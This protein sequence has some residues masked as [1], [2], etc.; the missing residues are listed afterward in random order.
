MNQSPAVAN[1]LCHAVLPDILGFSFLCAAGWSPVH[2]DGGAGGGHAGRLCQCICIQLVVPCYDNH[3]MN[4][5]GIEGLEWLVARFKENF[6]SFSSV[7]TRYRISM[8]G[9][10]R[11]FIL[12]ICHIHMLVFGLLHNLAWCW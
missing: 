11:V 6:T 5:V 10:P 2:S 1:Q 4:V 9:K 12:S 3:T 8:Q 7:P